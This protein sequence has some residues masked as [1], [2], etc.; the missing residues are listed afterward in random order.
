MTTTL[1]LFPHEQ[2]VTVCLTEG[3][4]GQMDNVWRGTVLSQSK[5]TVSPALPYLSEEEAEVL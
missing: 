2:N 3:L 1:C 5:G 4:S